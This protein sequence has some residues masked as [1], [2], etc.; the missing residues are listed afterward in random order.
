MRKISAEIGVAPDGTWDVYCKDQPFTG[1]GNTPEE[2]KAD[3]AEQMRVYKN[4]LKELG[5]KYPD[6]LDGEFEIEYDYDIE[7]ILHYYV[8]SGKLSL[9]GLEKITGI[10]QKQLWA[11]LNG[12][13]P[14]KPQ[15]ERIAR[16]LHSFS[17]ELRSIFP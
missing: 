17:E 5:M 10:N 6:F 9:A 12:T 7:S 14:R 11:Y 2:A 3:M 1:A 8:G 4:T 15:R 13:K 16:G